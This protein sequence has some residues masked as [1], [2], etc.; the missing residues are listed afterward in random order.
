MSDAVPALPC[1]LVLHARVE[2]GQRFSCP[3]EE[4]AS[5]G[6][7]FESVATVIASALALHTLSQFACNLQVT[8][9]AQTGMALLGSAE[10]IRM[11]LDVHEK[12]KR[13][14]GSFLALAFLVAS[15]S[16]ANAKKMLAN[17]THN[18]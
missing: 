16:N 5:Y 1:G 9:V 4:F 7:R 11:T 17:S 8:A 2:I 6:L 3:L 15:V 12:T 13:S 14:L 18:T 10:I